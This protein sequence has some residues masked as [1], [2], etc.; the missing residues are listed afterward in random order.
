MSEMVERVAKALADS[1]GDKWENVPE[2]KS[3][4]T[5]KRGLFGGRYRDINERFRHDYLEDAAAA[6]DAMRD[7]P[8][9]TTPRRE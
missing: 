2:N 8:N 3:Q 5:E 7:L 4:W 6:I 9:L 1:H